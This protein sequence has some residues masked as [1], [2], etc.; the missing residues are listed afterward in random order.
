MSSVEAMSR[1][2]HVPSYY[3]ASA[4]PHPAYPVLARSVACDVC[5]VGGGYTGLSAA[6][7]LAERGLDVVLLEAARVGWGASGRNGGQINP[8]FAPGMA[9]TMRL[10]GRDDARRLWAMAEEAKAMIAARVERHG[11][12][13]DL[14]EGYIHAASKP[15]HMA[16]IEAEAR[17]LRGEFAY[18][19]LRVIGRD[20]AHAATGSTRFAGAMVDRG[21]GHLHPLN[22]ALGLAAAAAAAGVRIH[23]GSRVLAIETGARPVART[24][25]G[26]VRARHLLLAGNAYLGRL[27]PRLAGRIM[28]VG[29]YILATAPLGQARADALIPGRE[30]VC[31][32][33]FVL[34]YFRLS[35]DH[36][37]LFGGRVSYLGRES[38]PGLAGAMRRRMLRTYPE[39][40]DVTVDYLWGGH[41][42]ISRNRLPDIGRLDGAVYYAQGF[43]GQGVALTGLAGKL[44]A[45]AIAGTA[46]R[47]D[48]FARIGH[49]RFPGGPALR[50]PSLVLATTWYRLRDLLS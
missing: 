47:F 42:A 48:V 36:R 22:Y 4:N 29:T 15:G 2:D 28:P 11:I 44:I 26:E 27:A 21:S 9:A 12:E 43:S 46:E 6:L 41:V 10:V 24:G 32:S 3:A 5:V 37:M 39:L 13:C 8:G 23:E 17:L 1:P 34:D 50:L 30:A 7:H 45:E 31:D 38:W 19:R 33:S 20:E 49:R 25:R 18:D 40:A 35:A 14:A 16:A